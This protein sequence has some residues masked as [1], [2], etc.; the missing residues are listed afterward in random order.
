MVNIFTRLSNYISG[1][2]SAGSSQEE[3]VAPTLDTLTELKKSANSK[4]AAGE[5]R[6]PIMRVTPEGDEVEDARIIDLINDNDALVPT[7]IDILN[8]LVTESGTPMPYRSSNILKMMYDLMDQPARDRVFQVFRNPPLNNYR[9]F[10]PILNGIMLAMGDGGLSL[11][12]AIQECIIVF[13]KVPLRMTSNDFAAAIEAVTARAIAAIEDIENTTL[14]AITDA[15]AADRERRAA[16][17]RVRTATTFRA[18]FLA[19][20]IAAVAAIVRVGASGRRSV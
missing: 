2:T 6:L 16:I 14:K 4:L 3:T 9:Q 8:N 17:V 15:Y 19:S 5:N 7:R 10:L 13:S 12:M 1:Q 18:V 20:S 11:G